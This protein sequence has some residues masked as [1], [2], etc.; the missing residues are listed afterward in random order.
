MIN[1][2]AE[3]NIP[4]TFA[5]RCRNTIFSINMIIHGLK[6]GFLQMSILPPNVRKQVNDVLES[7][8]IT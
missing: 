7:R 8:R 5:P 4:N 6:S 3:Y 1:N 2:P